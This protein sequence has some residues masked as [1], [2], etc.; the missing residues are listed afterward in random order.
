[1]LTTV[2]TH[3][4][5]DVRRNPEGVILESNLSVI[6]FFKLLQGTFDLRICAALTTQ[7]GLYLLPVFT[8]HVSALAVSFP[9][10]LCCLPG[11]SGIRQ[12]DQ[13]G[14]ATSLVGLK[15]RVCRMF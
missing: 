6:G 13:T 12:L 8:L 14:P 11:S 10:R 15:L 5:A 3:T 7:F 1:M 2:T 4:H 9:S